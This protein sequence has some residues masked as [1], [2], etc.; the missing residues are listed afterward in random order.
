[1]GA[2][3]LNFSTDNFQNQNYVRFY[4]NRKRVRPTGENLRRARRFAAGVVGTVDYRDSNQTVA[5]K[6]RDDHFISKLGEEAVRAVF[7]SLGKAVRGPDYEIYA[8]KGKSWDS[9]LYIDGVGLGVKTQKRSAALR[10]GLSWTFQQ[11]GYRN[12]PVLRRPAA[13]VTFAEVDDTDPD[14]PVIVY[15]CYQIAELTF[16]EPKLAHLRGK[17]RVVYETDLPRF[18]KQRL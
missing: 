3:G 14:F 7:L 18:N 1:M 15:P 8:A 2:N 12:D 17:K 6:I 16:G 9:D 11:S 13:W 10:Y 5:T 4:T